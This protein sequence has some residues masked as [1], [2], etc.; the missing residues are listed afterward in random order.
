MEY[1]ECGASTLRLSVIGAG[2]W[3]FGGGEYWGD[4]N[5]RDV[6]A[7]VHASIEHGINYFD[8]AEAYNGGRSEISLGQ[9]LQGIP[10]DKVIIGTKVSPPHCYAGT[11]EKH[12][13]ESL[14]RLRT[15][16]IDLYMIHWPIHPH[17]VR[18]FTKDEI[19]I[20]NPPTITE[21]IEAMMRLLETGK[22]RRIGV[23]N[24][25]DRRLSNDIPSSVNIAV[26][27]LPYNLLCRAIE[28]DTLPTCAGKGIGII[29]YMT[30]LQGILAGI[31]PTLHDV[32]A[33]QR[34]TR[35][36]NCEGTPLCRHGE[37]GFESE[38]EQALAAIRTVA[39]DSG[40][41]MAGLSTKWVMANKNITCALIGARSVAELTANLATVSQPLDPWV[42]DQLNQITDELKFRLGNHCD[43]YESAENDRT[44]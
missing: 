20:N 33:W 38:T 37:K 12:C 34:R 31:Y 19:V 17:S 32:P 14:R 6:D 21:A 8:T 41:T 39:L 23:S 27:E 13:E 11:L 15:D 35:H 10:R 26:N 28:Y 5:Q 43:Y 4:Q 1:R 2:C 44:L 24:Y 22:I 7:V 36:F 29:G 42:V 18:H 9:A 25:S 3:A 30:L 40:M 16:Y